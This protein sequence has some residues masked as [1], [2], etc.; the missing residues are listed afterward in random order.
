MRF[1][2]DALL[3]LASVAILLILFELGL[4]VTGSKY[5]SSFYESD[6]VLYMTLRPNAQGWEAKEGE[7][8]VRINSVGMRDRE[9]N[10]NPTPDTTR[11]A[12]LGDSMVMA[13]QVPF[14]NT[15][16]QVLERDLDRSLADS[17]EVL[18]FG[19]GGYTLTQ[20]YLTL[21]NRVWAFHPAIVLLVLSPS[22][23]PSCSRRLYQADVPYFVLR[24]GR[25][26]PDA[27]NRAP[28]GSTL[29]ERRQHSITGDLMNRFRLLQLVRR[30]TQDGIPREIARLTG[31]RPT[32][33]GNIMAMWYQPPA[34][35]EQQEAWRVAE[36]LLSAMAQEAREHGAEFWISAVG[37]EIE[38]DPDPRDRNNFLQKNQIAGFDYSESRLQ[39]MAEKRGIGF[40]ALEPALLRYSEQHQISL[41]G[42][43]NTAPNRGHWNEAGNAAAAGILANDLAAHSLALHRSAPSPVH[44]SDPVA[45]QGR[46]HRQGQQTASA[47]SDPAVPNPTERISGR[48]TVSLSR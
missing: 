20:E 45:P 35:A 36:A 33:N 18:N 39:S 16:A 6:P 13:E 2:R 21:H 26:T 37:N 17:A 48:S 9:H 42:F 24:G 28:A 47:V 14:E 4:R 30:A 10:L 5:E 12:L 34:D 29:E 1:F 43:F 15:M 7:N 8:Y 3:T 38:E 32:H 11:I 31:A 41:R 40:I 46:P 25:L 23:V 19:V 27:A 44:A 22:S